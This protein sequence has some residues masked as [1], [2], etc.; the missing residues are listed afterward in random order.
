MTRHALLRAS[1]IAANRQS[2]QGAVPKMGGMIHSMEEIDC[3]C[4]LFHRFK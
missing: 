1:E 4:L 2:Y 3:F